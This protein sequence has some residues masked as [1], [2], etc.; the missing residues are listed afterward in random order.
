MYSFPRNFI[1]GCATSAYQVEGAW[2][3]DGKGESIWDQ[4]VHTPGKIERGETGNIACDQYHRYKEDIDI[5]KQLG[6]SAYRFSV[7]WPRI[8]PDGKGKINSRG[9]DHYDKLVDSLLAAGITPWITLYHWDLPQKLQDEG[10]W[11]NR[12]LTDYF[13][14]YAYTVAEK[15]AD[16]VK[17]WITFNEPWV[18]CH[19]AYGHGAHPPAHKDMKEVLHSSYHLNLA[20]GKAYEA[21]K[22][23]NN[24]VKIGISEVNWNYYNIHNDEKSKKIIQFAH[25]ENNQI[26]WDPILKGTY[27]RTVA[28]HYKNKIPRINPDELKIMNRYDFYGLQYYFDMIVSNGV[29]E[30]RALNRY[31]YPKFDYTE[32][33][34]PVTPDGLY[35]QLMIMS[36]EYKVQN[37][38][39]TENGSAW[40]D[41]LNPEGKTA[42]TKRQDFLIKHLYRVYQAIQD[43]APVTGYFVWSFMDNFEWTSGYRPRFGL[44]YTEYA[45]QKRYIKDSGFLY[46]KIIAQNGLDIDC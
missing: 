17:Y 42:D 24:G 28:S 7:S 43:G 33:G 23:V 32:M 11:P 3:L 30:N 5:M 14:E 44:V 10:G 21:L 46:Q 34:W 8:Y 37:I 39:I 27:P 16:R 35:R 1:W 9:L 45:S 15:L 18:I 19:L 36:E 22:S 38:V 25:A 26:Y 13:S 2:N 29:I 6:I 31:K 41:I 20:H 40:Q 4:F 12:K